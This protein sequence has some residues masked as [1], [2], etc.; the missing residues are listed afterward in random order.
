MSEGDNQE[1]DFDDKLPSSDIHL[2]VTPSK[3]RGKNWIHCPL[4]KRKLFSQKEI[5]EQ[6]KNHHK[7]EQKKK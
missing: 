6:L 3:L 1:S 2:D 5:K 7:K 4:C